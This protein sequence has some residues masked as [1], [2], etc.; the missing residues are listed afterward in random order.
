MIQGPPVILFCFALAAAQLAA[1]TPP[2]QSPPQ[3]QPTDGVK[4]AQLT[5]DVYT[6]YKKTAESKK[7]DWKKLEAQYLPEIVKAG[8]ANPCAPQKKI[9]TL[10]ELMRVAGK[11]YY[12]AYSKY[13]AKWSDDVERDMQENQKLWADMRAHQLDIPTLIKTEESALEDNK[14]KQANLPVQDEDTRREYDHLLDASQQ[15]LEVMRATLLDTS[16][17]DDHIKSTQEFWNTKTETIK[18]WREAVAMGRQGMETRY[19]S[20][21]QQY[22]TACTLR[23]EP[24]P[25]DDLGVKK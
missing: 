7:A 2:V 6:G 10:I 21:L 24:H 1:Q 15:K 16:S 12:L 11:E 9:A 18:K 17:I 23:T 22:R 25:M 5:E 8:A 3:E 4:Q 20:I 14:R 13:L 19:D